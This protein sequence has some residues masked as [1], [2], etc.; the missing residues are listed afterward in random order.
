VTIAL[1]LKRVEAR[2]KLMHLRQAPATRQQCPHDVRLR[3]PVAMD[4]SAERPLGNPRWQAY[5]LSVIAL[6]ILF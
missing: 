2:R 4:Q 3:R 6:T 1:A 5:R